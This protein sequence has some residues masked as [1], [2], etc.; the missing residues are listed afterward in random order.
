[1]QTTPRLLDQW[2]FLIVQRNQ[3]MTAPK[4]YQSPV[5]AAQLHRA[6]VYMPNSQWQA[7]EALRVNTTMSVS[8]YISYLITCATVAK[9]NNVTRTSN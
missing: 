8:Q 3:T 9:E 1:M 2:P 7:V 5:S 6:Y 4:P